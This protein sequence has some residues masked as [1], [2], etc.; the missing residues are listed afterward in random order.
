MIQKLI[1]TADVVVVGAGLAGLRAATE[2]RRF[3]ADVLLIDKSLIGISGNSAFAG[4]GFKTCLPGMDTQIEKQYNTPEGH[5]Q[6]TILYGDYMGEQPLVE[7]MSSEA[8]GRVLQLEDVG[9]ENFMSLCTQGTS[10]N[11]GHDVTQAFAANLKTIGVK[12]MVNTILLE[13]LVEDGVVAG[14]LFFNFF[15]ERFIEVR[16]NSVILTTGGAG[17]SFAR[18]NVSSA[19]IGDGYAI[20]HR[21]GADLIGMEF[22]MFDP[23]ILDEPGLPL[24]YVLPCFARFYGKLVNAKGE[25]F[26]PNYLE[27]VG[28][29]E[30]PFPVRYG[31]LTPDVRETI[32]RAMATEIYEG[33]DKDGAVFLDCRDVP[34]EYW[35]RDVPGRAN[36]D[37]ILRKF[38]ITKK[39]MRVI[40]GATTNLGGI[41]INDRCESSVPGLYAA[42]E[43]AGLVHGA[44]RLG[45]N[46]LTDCLV[47]GARAGREAARRA[48]G[49][50]APGISP[51][52]VGAAIERVTL[53]LERPASLEGDPNNLHQELKQVAWKGIGVIRSEQSL[54]KCLED[55]N[56]IQRTRLPRLFASSMSNLRK[57]LEVE[58]MVLSHEITARS[59]LARAESRGTHFR[60]DVPE[61]DNKRFLR[62]FITR[63]SEK[64]IE[65]VGCPIPVTRVPLPR[66]PHRSFLDP[67]AQT[68]RPK[69]TQ[70][71][72]QLIW[73]KEQVPA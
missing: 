41:H 20:A 43:V 72:G 28:T 67:A 49:L 59:A 3:G 53:L 55:L 25:A 2:A 26:L 36:R 18:N 38:P 69:E 37:A 16:S 7:A 61:I 33:R 30:D 64:G 32:S 34:Y 21:A 24:W 68:S 15:R 63:Q 42:G 10:E 17:A 22:V 39:L 73:L 27:M 29:M 13:I 8:P 4:G 52:C 62:N 50:K 56:Q 46:A 9:V 5:F 70:G 40:P 48:A 6:D 60:V 12:V 65:C 23:Y 35:D 45:G 66:G 47:F 44:R 71:D 19:I 1:K 51:S 54:T 11:G 31:A 58:Y 57:A 14:A